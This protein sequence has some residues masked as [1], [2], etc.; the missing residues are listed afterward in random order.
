MIWLF[1]LALVLG[2]AFAA[3]RKRWMRTAATDTEKA[4]DLPRPDFVGER[5]RS[6]YKVTN[7]QSG[8]DQEPE[9]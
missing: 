9:K 6:K 7:L 4:S 1:T 3:S 2:L 5:R 8:L